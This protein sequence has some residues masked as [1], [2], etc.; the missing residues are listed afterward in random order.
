MDTENLRSFL[1]VA[2]HGSFT[3]AAGRLNLAQST[4]SARIRGLEE[5]LGRRLFVRDRDGV[6]LTR[7]AGSSCR[8]PPPSPAPGSSRGRTSPFPMAMRACCG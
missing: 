6:T 1:E 2:E 5:Q 7:P 4:V 8:T 3:V